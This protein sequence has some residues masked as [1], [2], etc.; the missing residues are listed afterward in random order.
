[1]KDDGNPSLL[2]DEKDEENEKAAA[3]AQGKDTEHVGD[4]HLRDEKPPGAAMAFVQ[5]CS[6]FWVK[7]W[8]L[9]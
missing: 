8:K 5:G 2:G 7:F 9:F 1:M 3:K 4:L 6:K